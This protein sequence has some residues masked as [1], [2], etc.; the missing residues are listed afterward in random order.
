MLA[1]GHVRTASSSFS[2]SGSGSAVG[3]APR[4][5][6]TGASGR[7]SELRSALQASLQSLVQLKDVQNKLQRKLDDQ[8]S[9]HRQEV[10][11]LQLK[12]KE[13]EADVESMQRIK[14]K[15]VELEDRLAKV[16]QRLTKL[17]ELGDLVNRL[18]ALE[19][20]SARRE[21]VHISPST[22][23]AIRAITSPAD[24]RSKALLQNGHA[25]TLHTAT[26]VDQS[27]DSQSMSR[28][29]SGSSGKRVS[30]AGSG[31]PVLQG[32][33][34]LL[35]SLAVRG[36]ASPKMPGGLPDIVSQ[37]DGDTFGIAG[38]ANGISA[39][40]PRLA[41]PTSS[42]TTRSAEFGASRTDSLR[43]T[44]APVIGQG[45]CLV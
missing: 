14:Q 10:G 3:T 27:P 5:N 39:P 29:S 13:L 19:T 31:D 11:A 17:D 41:S 43:A 25:P 38:L 6:G 45:K 33:H 23:Q 8:A 24:N 9:S 28:T 7:D 44:K 37:D 42:K 18:E 40:E 4:P 30:F 36:K 20:V 2:S 16:E 21:A 35:G 26:L 34:D 12:V 32:G 15:N 22:P 1:N